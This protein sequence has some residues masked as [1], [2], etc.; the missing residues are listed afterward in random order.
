[1]LVIVVCLSSPRCI[2]LNKPC[3]SSRCIYLNKPCLSPRYIYLNKPCFIVKVLPMCRKKREYEVKRIVKP[4]NNLHGE[5]HTL[6]WQV[7]TDHWR[8][9]TVWAKRL[10]FLYNVAKTIKSSNKTVLWK[11]RPASWSESKPHL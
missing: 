11:V 5:T 9:K 4:Y 8:I 3:L 7:L 2:Y 10:T 6:P 1:M